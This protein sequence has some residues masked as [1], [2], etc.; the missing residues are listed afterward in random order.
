M[1]RPGLSSMLGLFFENGPLHVADDYSLFSNNN[2]WDKLTDYIWID[3]PVTAL[4]GF[5]AN[6]VKVFPGLK[7][8]PLHLTGERYARTYIPYIM[9]AYFG[10]TDPPVNLT[11]IAIGDGTIGSAI[12]F[13]ILP[14]LTVI[15][16]YPQLIGYVPDVYNYFKTQNHLCG[17][18]LNLTYPQTGKFPTLNLTVEP[19]I[20]VAA[21]YRSD[22]QR[23]LKRNVVSE[24]LKAGL[25]ACHDDLNDSEERERRRKATRDSWKLE[26]RD[27]SALLNGTVDTWYRYDLY[28]EMIDYAL[29]FSIPWKGNTFDGFDVYNIPDAL[30][31][32]ARMDASVFLNDNRTR[33]AIHAPT[34]KDWESNINYMFS[35]PDGQDP[36]VKPMAFL[37]DLAANATKHGVGI[38]VYS[39]NNDSLVS[40][41][42]TQVVIQNTTFGGIQGF[43]R[44]PSTSWFDDTGSFAGIIHQERNWT[45]VLIKGAGHLIPQQQPE[46]VFVVLRKF[47][48]GSN[49]TGLVLTTTNNTT[50]SSSSSSPAVVV[51]DENVTLAKGYLPGQDEI[52]VGLGTTQSSTVYP[53]ETRAAWE[54][55]IATANGNIT[56][57]FGLNSSMPSATGS[58]GSAGSGAQG[59]G[60]VGR[61]GVGLAMGVG[62]VVAAMLI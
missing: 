27:L 45:Y 48:L 4:F 54:S 22:M 49:Q 61:G 23:R 59:S 9:K 44:P 42:G 33:T 50:S 5:L 55:F 46:R 62:S 8:H 31:P 6:L 30:D 15:E 56:A 24:S 1:R 2:S 29:N 43:T 52:S 19:G 21:R 38:V 53:S 16:T 37:D 32:E 58:A 3:Q 35:G 10:L 7:T 20:E 47:I 41:T 34:S 57:G 51:G 14:T 18:D 11:K 28:D 13:E 39:G 26:K 17:F 25:F 36:S 40:H 12:V 60:A